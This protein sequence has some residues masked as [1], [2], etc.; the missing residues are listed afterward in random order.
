MKLVGPLATVL[1]ELNMKPL[2][3][4]RALG[5]DPAGVKGTAEGEVH[6]RLPM[7]K[8]LR[9]AQVDYSARGML[10]GVAIDKILFGRDLGAGALRIAVG[11]GGVDLDGNAKLNGVPITLNWKENFAGD[12]IRTQYR[13]KG[14][15]DDAARHQLGIDWL[16][17]MVSGPVGVDLT[18]ARQRNDF[19]TSD[20]TLDLG[21]ATLTIDKLGWTKKPGVPATA[22]LTLSARNELPARISDL[23]IHGG[24]LDA[25]MD[26]T[27]SGGTTDA[28]V[29]RANIYRLA[30]GQTDVAGVVAQRPEGGWSVTLRGRRFDASRLLDDLQKATPSNEREPPLAIEAELGEMVIAPGRTVSNVH[31][32]LFS[33]GVHWQMAQ[34]DATPAAGKK[35][36]LRF[37]GAAGDGNFRLTSDDLGAVLRLLDISSKVRGGTVTVTAHADDVDSHRT[38]AGKIVGNDYRMVDAPAFAQLLAL[39]SFTG[40]ASMANG[41][42]IPFSRMQGDFVLDNGTV[43]LR[44]ARAFGEAMGINAS[45]EFDY[46]HDTL[47]MSGTIVPAYL[48]NSLL[49]NIPGIDLLMGGQGQGIFAAKFRVAGSTADP[50]ISVNPLSALAPGFLRGLFLFDAGKPSQ[51][52]AKR[53]V[54]PKGG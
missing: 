14:A 11:R 22:H 5:V 4:A 28:K 32:K 35:L 42:G 8:N 25:L 16:P 24:G 1:D 48:L 45:G 30:V 36:A 3:Y 38:L 53:D 6:F 41:Q 15:F 52:N 54:P 7:K 12:P 51:D 18:F 9:F 44:N 26:I 34:I 29:A 27:L 33:D 39:A 10:T 31:A 47:D 20:A 23:R 2:R 43:E 13:V 46:R 37:G 49:S 17:D 21:N 40:P 50:G 19:A